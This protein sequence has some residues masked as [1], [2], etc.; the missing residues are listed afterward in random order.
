M[1]ID[2]RI[3]HLDSHALYGSVEEDMMLMA[4]AADFFI[5]NPMR[6][7]PFHAGSF[8]KAAKVVS[9]DRPERA[10]HMTFVSRA[11]HL[12]VFHAVKLQATQSRSKSVKALFL[13]TMPLLNYEA[14][15][16]RK[17]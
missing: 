16:K 12:P 7:S 17:Y 14:R 10:L 6:T 13:N 5:K 2:L 4:E 15:N 8:F 9:A 3:L 11:F 1:G